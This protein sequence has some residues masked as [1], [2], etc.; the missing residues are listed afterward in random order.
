MEA[1]DLLARCTFPSPGTTVDCAVSGGP[2]SLAL[3]VL[4]VEAGLMVT[5]WHVDHG[6]RP[7]SDAEGERVAV[8]ADSLGAAAVSVTAMVGDGPNLEARAREARLDALPDGVLTGHTA[9]DQA[10]TVL[11]N[12]LRGSGI[13]GSAGIGD[14]GR[15]PLL[16]L[17]RSE[18]RAFCVACGL[19]PLDDPM[20]VDPR[21]VRNRIRNEVLPLL[22]EVSDRDP[23]PLL[24]RHAGLAGEAVVL[25]DALIA[26]IDP[27][28]ARTLAVLSPELARLALRGWLTGLLG[29]RPPDAAAIDRVFDVAVGLVRATEV[30]GGLRIERSR[31]RLRPLPEGGHIDGCR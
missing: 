23:V 19:E 28:D 16:G 9:D 13:H 18:T 21:F 15:R 26:D 17:R 1:A 8:V 14:P 29:G 12:L 31:G 24:A 20:N 30:T 2:D 6:L 25:L 11:L 3:L 27:T 10:E 4:A 5:A 22:A 7:G